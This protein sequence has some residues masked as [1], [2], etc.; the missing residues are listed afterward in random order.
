MQSHNARIL[1]VRATILIG[2][3]SNECKALGDERRCG[4]ARW[5]ESNNTDLT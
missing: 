2:R 4:R 5:H 3:T 1:G